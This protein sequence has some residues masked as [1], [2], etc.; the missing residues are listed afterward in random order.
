MTEAQMGRL[1][2]AFSQADTST[3]RKY[4]G[5]GLGLTIGKRLV[6]MMGGDIQVDSAPGKGSCFIFTAAFGPGTGQ[7]EA[8]ERAAEAD[9]GDLRVLIVDD[10]G[11]SRQIFK[12]MI[13]SFDFTADDAT[14]GAEALAR[15]RRAQADGRPYGLVIMDWKMP[16]MDGIET[17]VRSRNTAGPDAQPKIILVTA[18][19]HDQAARLVEEAGIDGL[20]SNPPPLRTFSTP[21]SGHSERVSP[22]RPP[23]TR[24]LHWRRKWRAG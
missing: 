3:T 24:R 10:N 9:L 14:S 4:G 8:P 20:S 19:D 1:F 21:S 12:E 5:T 17:A 15:I 22:G 7:I 16:G 11:T 6:E 13:E 18:Y 23:R 2:Q